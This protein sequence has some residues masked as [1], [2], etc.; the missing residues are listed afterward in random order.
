MQTEPLV[1]KITTLLSEIKSSE[2]MEFLSQPN[3]NK[4]DL[5][6][7]IIESKIG[8]DKWCTDSECANI[9]EEIEE[10]IAA[11][12]E[13]MIYFSQAPVRLDSV[14]ADQYEALKEF[15]TNCQ[16][17]GLYET[18]D[19]LSEFRDKLSRQLA[20]TMIRLFPGRTPDA[21]AI[22]RDA[23]DGQLRDRS[24]STEPELSLHA[25]RLLKSA[26]VEGHFMRLDV[27]G[28]VVIQVNGKVFN[29][30]ADARDAAR[31]DAAI[32]ELEQL[33]LIEGANYKREYFQ[34]T[35]AGYERA[36][37]IAPDV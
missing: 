34:V 12:K 30:P 35:H 2:I 29:T 11:G 18:Y 22:G 36:D 33:G 19:S 25:Q 9:I 6:T 16:G 7:L 20:T 13:A 8:Y 31:W 17:R 5:L 23:A 4:V 1:N 14:D 32:K 3:L 21:L 10:H 37:R 26:S 15:R 27:S 24:Q 28:G